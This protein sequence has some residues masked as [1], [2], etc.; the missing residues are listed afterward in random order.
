MPT[1]WPVSVGRATAPGRPA[2]SRASRRDGT[3]RGRSRR[4]AGARRGACPERV[5]EPIG[6]DAGGHGPPVY[7]RVPPRV[8]FMAGRPR[9]RSPH[10][11]GIDALARLFSTAAST[12]GSRT[13]SMVGRGVIHR[14][15]LRSR[16]PSLA[17]RRPRRD[18]GD[19]ADHAGFG[20]PD[21]RNLTAR[22]L[23]GL[24]LR[25]GRPLVP[26]QH[27][28]TITN[29]SGGSIDRVEFNTIAARLGGMRL[30]VVEVEGRR[31]RRRRSR[32]QTI[33]VPLGGVLPRATRS[34]SVST[35]TPR[36]RLARRLELDVHAGQRHRRCLPLDPVGQPCDARSP[37]EPRRPVRDTERARRSSSTSP[38]IGDWSSHRPPTSAS[39][40]RRTG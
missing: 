36:S 29:T 7:G 15:P 5:D 21:Q 1:T 28:P 30:H 16:A 38:R 18:V 3:T 20:E 26:G 32:D 19:R 4:S 9:V 11:Q 6:D 37:A 33:V 12:H 39:R 22:Y 10:D 40:A 35:T 34:G 14:R 8:E 2:E 25:F 17:R 13:C 27:G 31:A 24:N 23:V